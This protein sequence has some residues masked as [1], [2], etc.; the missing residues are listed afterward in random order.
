[1]MSPILNQVAEAMDGEVVI[2]KLNV[3]HNQPIAK[4][5]KV[6]NIPTLVL[7]QDGQE[8]NRFV[9]VKTKKFLIAEL[10]KYSQ[11]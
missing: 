5:S 11:S 3:D 2:A 8:V 6:R 4:K 1:M 10:R 9:G 7:F